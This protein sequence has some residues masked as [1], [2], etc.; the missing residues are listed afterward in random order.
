MNIVFLNLADNDPQG[1]VSKSVKALTNKYPEPTGCLSSIFSNNSVTEYNLIPILDDKSPK[2]GNNDVSLSMIGNHSRRADKVMVAIHGNYD[3]RDQGFITMG[4]GK[5]VKKTLSLDGLCNYIAPLFPDGGSY[6]LTLVMCYGARTSNYRFNQFSQDMDWSTSFAYKFYEKMR[7]GKK[8]YMEAF[9][10]AVSIDEASGKFK[11][12][13]EAAID[14]EINL[15]ENESTYADVTIAY[16]ALID[17]SSKEDSDEYYKKYQVLTGENRNA[18]PSTD[19]RFQ[20]GYDIVARYAQII[21]AMTNKSDS[22]TDIGKI[23]FIRIK[24]TTVV[25]TRHP[26]YRILYP[27]SSIK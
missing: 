22:V 21:V 16:Q 5:T 7:I 19:N 2:L 13:T 11:I 1:I 6:N 8:L 15:I 17:N 26:K 12:Q 18:N 10:G 24:N 25:L 9:T 27:P 23:V 4:F 14:A 3:N 20:V